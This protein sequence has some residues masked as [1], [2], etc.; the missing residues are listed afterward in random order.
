VTS[1]H[2]KQLKD[3]Q[4][5]SRAIHTVLGCMKCCWAT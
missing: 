5:V 4:E 2:D 1:R 3:V